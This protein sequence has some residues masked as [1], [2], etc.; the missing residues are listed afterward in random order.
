MILVGLFL[1]LKLLIHVDDTLNYQ[2]FVNHYEYDLNDD[3]SH[4]AQD[5]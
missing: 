1:T 5:K 2:L 3:C 4:N